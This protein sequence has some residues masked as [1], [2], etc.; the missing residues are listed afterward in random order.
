MKKQKKTPGSRTA[1]KKEAAA[2]PLAWFKEHQNWTAFGLF[3]LFIFTFFH[4]V[5][6]SGKIFFVPDNM[7]PSALTAPLW[8]ALREEGIHANWTPY[9]FGGMPTS[10]SL[11]FTPFYYFPYVLLMAVET[12]I[13]LPPLF[14]HIIHYPFAALGIYLFL[15]DQKVDFGPAVFGGIVF[16]FTTHFISMAS[17]GHGSKLMTVAYLP[18]ALWAVSR[19]F[20]RT[21]FLYV[22]LSALF[23]GL[24]FQRGHVQIVYYTWMLLGFFFVFTLIQRLRAG[25]TNMVLPMTLRFAGVTLLSLSM[26]AV[27]YLPILEYTP[28]SIRGASS[29]LAATTNNAG[30]G[31]D[32]AT[33]WSFSIGEMFTFIVPSFFGF[34]GATYWGT[35]PFTDY[36]H[37]AGVLVVMLA[38]YTIIRVRSGH[39]P[40]LAT[41][42]AIALLISFG[43]NF[44]PVFNL[45]Y[46]FAPFF[47][48]FRVPSMILILVQMGFA[49]LAGIG[50]QHLLEWVKPEKAKKKKSAYTNKLLVAAAVVGGLALVFTMIQTGLADFFKGFYTVRYQP[51]V[52]AQINSQRFDMLLKDWWIMSLIVAAGLAVLHFAKK[53]KIK[54]GL[55]VLAISAITIIDLWR[56]NTVINKPVAAR[57]MENYLKPDELAKFVKQDTSVFRILPVN[58]A[59]LGLNLFDENRWAAQGI[60][61]VG[62]YHAAK[63]R[64]YQ[65]LMEISSFSGNYFDRYYA[66][67]RSGEQPALV[68]K[69]GQA[70]LHG[71]YMAMLNAKYLVSPY[72]IAH[73][74]LEHKTVVRHFV[75][76]Q[77]VPLVIQENKKVLDRAWLVG[78]TKVIPEPKALLHYLNSVDFA[79]QKQVVLYEAPALL[80]EPDSLATAVLKKYNV[81]EIVVE[82]R[83]EKPQ[84]LVLSDV[85]YPPGWHATID[86]EETTVY[87]ANHAFR[88]ISVP[89]GEHLI[90]YYFDSSGQRTG[91]WLTILSSLAVIAL[92]VIGVKRGENHL[93]AS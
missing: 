3:T 64:T 67:D 34:G 21:G 57:N 47:N 93:S 80:P 77:Y 45:F 18:L 30:L 9:I 22:G 16:M 10:G 86:G 14:A 52:Q 84:M 12:V 1:E 50:L 48:K 20:A 58:F 11:I 23:L 61:S 2:E 60:Q 69:S 4:E 91:L 53:Q 33:S 56:V 19:M 6:F 46:N 44:T 72:P 76:G 65:D 13:T 26:A 83:S 5:I 59:R 25:Q 79:P 43:K 36:P 87:Q 63:P 55:V 73:P 78:D 70:Q 81:Q 32:Y 8:Q 17:F 37:Y 75:N 42:M 66:I 29:A 51:D 54:P 90:R 35:M 31:F 82:T 27:L 62:G 74:D 28:F 41:A 38:L 85:Y 71:N 89:A 40:F 39:V 49:I 88:A 68:F 15:R 92:M 7:A 24:Q